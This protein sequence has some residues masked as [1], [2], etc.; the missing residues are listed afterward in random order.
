LLPL[1]HRVLLE[2][3]IMEQSEGFGF[4][5]SPA[6][7]SVAV[8]QQT[9]ARPTPLPKRPKG[10]W[11]IGLLLLASCGYGLWQAYDSFLRYRS[12]GIVTGRVLQLSS[13]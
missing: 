12:Y 9:I 6:Y 7:P 11:F 4:P 5:Q 1:A 13:P 8:P 2:T 3:T 10:R